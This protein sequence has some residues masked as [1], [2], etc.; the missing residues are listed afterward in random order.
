MRQ[1][2]DHIHLTLPL[3]IADEIDGIAGAVGLTGASALE[4]L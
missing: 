4:R 3:W 2:V 1:H